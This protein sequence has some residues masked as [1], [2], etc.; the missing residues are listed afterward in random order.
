MK[1]L[2]HKNVLIIGN[3]A[4]EYAFAK[5]LSELDYIEKIF[6]APGND[7]MKEFCECVDIRENSP[8]ELLEFALE[9]NVD[10]TVVLSEKAIKADVVGFFTDN[11]QQVFGPTAKSAEICT[12]KSYGKRFMYKLRVPT[13]KFGIFEKSNLATDYVRN[14]ELPIVVKTDEFRGINGTLVCGSFDIARAFID[15]SFLRGEQRIILEDFVYGHEFSFYVITDGYNALPLT[16][17]ANYKFDLDGDGG[18][19]TPGMG[20]FAPDYKISLDNEQFIM[21][22]I[23]F[24]ALET[25]AQNETPYVGILGVDAVLTPDG[26]VVALEFNSSLQEHD[27]Q[28]VLS[29]INDDLYLLMQACATGSFADDYSNINISDDFSVSAVLSSGR[30]SGA[31]IYGLDNLD[32]STKIAHFNTRKN[33]YLEYET[34]GGRTLLVTKNAKTISIAVNNLYEELDTITF[35]GKKYRKDLCLVNSY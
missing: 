3:C 17:V 14:A 27:C 5:K 21:N 29:L 19:L 18:L 7:A 32:E 13:P 20:C 25:L 11:G 23:I 34:V 22:E 28:S 12:C 15:E 2:N 9:N 30:K 35:E 24:P 4:K 10:L 16:S 33:K 31:I 6:V 1:K 8:I 26:E